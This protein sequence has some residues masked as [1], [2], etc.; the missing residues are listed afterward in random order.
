MKR[1]GFLLAATA[2]ASLAVSVAIA[3]PPPGKGKPAT[4]GVGC[5]PMITVVLK[6]TLTGATATTL[7]VNVTSGNRF[8]NAY[9]AAAQPTVIDVDT[10]T[11]VRRQ[12]LKTLGDLIIGDRV[13]V[14]ARVCKAALNEGAMPALTAV[15]V[16]A[17]SAAA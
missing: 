13:L 2:T 11:K 15:R 17:H 4:T 6:G 16:V 8:A 10:K 14:Q 12:G 5:K 9:V 3:A 7:S 1:I